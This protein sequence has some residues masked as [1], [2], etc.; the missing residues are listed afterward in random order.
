MGTIWLL[1]MVVVGVANDDVKVQTDVR[2]PNDPGFNTEQLCNEAGKTLADK[3]QIEIG[4]NNGLVFWKCQSASLDE[5][6]KGAVQSAPKAN[7]T[8]L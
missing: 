4:S 7:G 5:M 3:M 6:I 8:A 1:I 2:W